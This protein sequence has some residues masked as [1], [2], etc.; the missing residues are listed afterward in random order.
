MVVAPS[1][2]EEDR[3]RLCRERRTFIEERITHVHRIKGLLFARGVSDYAPLR[4]DRRARLEALR[5]GDG[6]DLPAHLKAQLGREL[7]RIELLLEQIKSVEAAQDALLA[8]ARKPAGEKAMPD[9]VTLLPPLTRLRPHSP[10]PP[11]TC[12]PS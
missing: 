5:T 2:E 9:P 10:P 12:A 8:A 1:P 7:D 3:L 11:S 6:R 4:R